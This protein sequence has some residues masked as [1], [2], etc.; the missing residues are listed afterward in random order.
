MSDTENQDLG[1]DELT[2]LKARATLLGIPFH[3][4]IGVEK[5]REKVLAAMSNAPAEAPKVEQPT[6]AAPQEETLAQRRKRMKNEA[7]RL[8]RIRL[9]CMNPAK[10]DWDG[11]IITVGN[12]LVGTLS[13]YVPFNADEGWHVPYMMYLQLRDRQCQVFTTVKTKNGV[14]IRQG[15]LIKEFA[16][17]ELPPLSELEIKELARRQA[18]AKGQE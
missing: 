1:Q 11:E 14:S 8:V 10:K 15:K 17:E 7:T 12:S 4:T 6:I 2:T 9:T 5:L 18:M 3:P 16:I 13:K